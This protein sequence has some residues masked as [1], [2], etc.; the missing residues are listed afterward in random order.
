ML[1][2]ADAQALQRLDALWSMD[3]G[4]MGVTKDTLMRDL[5]FASSLSANGV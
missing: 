1:Q 4:A 3:A 5:L 2:R